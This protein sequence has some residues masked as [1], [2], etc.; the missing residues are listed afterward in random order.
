MSDVL[1]MFIVNTMIPAT[2]LQFVAF[3]F[4]FAQIPHHCDAVHMRPYF[5]I[6]YIFTP[7]ISSDQDIEMNSSQTVRCLLR[8][9]KKTEYS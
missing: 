8:P 5:G 9:K 2:D 3:C 1:A 4:N 6:L 7:S